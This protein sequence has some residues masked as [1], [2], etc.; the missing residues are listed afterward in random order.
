MVPAPRTLAP[1][2]GTFEMFPI[3]TLGHAE[4]TPCGRCGVAMAL[5]SGGTAVDF[6]AAW[7][8][9]VHLAQARGAAW[10]AGHQFDEPADARSPEAQDHLPTRGPPSAPAGVG[11]RHPHLAR[12]ASLRRDADIEWR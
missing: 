3:W 12:P 2:T 4:V 7:V 6:P 8:P 5:D 10:R 1:E 11:Q 9:F